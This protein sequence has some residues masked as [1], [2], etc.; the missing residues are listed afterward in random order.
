MAV[1]VGAHGHQGK[2]FVTGPTVGDPA[3]APAPAVGSSE[4]SLPLG[5]T[6]MRAA[7]DDARCDTTEMTRVGFPGPTGPSQWSLLVEARTAPAWEAFADVQRRHGYLFREAAGG[8]Y[9]CR[10]IAGSDAYSLHAYGLALDL[11]PSKNGPQGTP[12][13]DQPVGFRLAVKALRTAAT[14]RQ[15]FSWGGD[16]SAAVQDPMHWQ[17]GATPAELAEGITDPGEDEDMSPADINEI[18]DAVVAKLNADGVKLARSDFNA[19]TLYAATVGEADKEP[20][21]ASVGAQ[22]RKI[23]QIAQDAE[24]P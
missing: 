9:N 20:K 5:T 8:T 12:T 6:T 10:Q 23:L 13:C 16:W 22:V 17:I 18:A 21:G 19:Q 24:S 11:N 7:Y 15:I 14:G 2:H 3:P 1:S 4:M